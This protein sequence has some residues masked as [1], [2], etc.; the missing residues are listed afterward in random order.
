M[1]RGTDALDEARLQGRLWTPARLSPDIWIDPNDATTLTVS[2][3][4]D[5][6]AARNKGT[7]ALQFTGTTQVALIASQRLSWMERKANALGLVSS[8]AYAIIPASKRFTAF[9]LY[10]STGDASQA[11]LG[12]SHQ[13]AGNSVLLN[14]NIG[15][16]AINDGTWRGVGAAPS[17]NGRI[18]LLSNRRTGNTSVDISVRQDGY[19]SGGTLVAADVSLAAATLGLG[20]HGTTTF[21]G[22]GYPMGEVLFWPTDI[23]AANAQRVEGYLAWKSLIPALLPASHPFRNRP[24]LIGD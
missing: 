9:C 2:G 5:I 7:A 19:S 21:T 4:G 12:L 17:F 15:G 11:L 16:F 14:E 10:V 18:S 8:A 24:P 22:K 13:V 1:P 3:A 6:T 23:G 20:G